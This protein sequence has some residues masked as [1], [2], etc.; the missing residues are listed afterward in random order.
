MILERIY[1]PG[2]AQVG[3]LIGVERAGVAAIIDPRRD[4]GEY[5]ALA[6]AAG[7]RITHAFETHVHADFVSGSL[8][9]ARATGATIHAGKLGELAFPHVPLNDGDVIEIGTLRV[10][11]MWTPGHTPEHVSYLVEDTATPTR[12]LT[13][14]TGD[15]LFVGEVGRP[16][17]LGHGRTD[18]LLDALYDSIFE[19]L[20]PL[21]DDIIVYPGHGAGSACGRTI[22]DADSTTMGQE[23]R[24]N[25][26]FRPR[27]RAA[28]R[29]AIM[30]G[31]PPAPTYYPIL[32]QVNKEG[33]APLEDLPGGE[34]LMVEELERSMAAGALVI[35]ALSPEAFG[36]AHIPGSIFV[37]LGANFPAWMGWLAPYDRDIILVLEHDTAYEAARTDLRRIGLDRV[38]GYLQSGIAAW[39]AS[40]RE[41]TSLPQISVHELR[42]RIE[43]DGLQVLDV[44]SPAEWEEGHIAGAQHRFAAAIAQGN[45]EIPDIE[46]LS[47][48]CGSGYRSSVAASLLQADGRAGVLN[49]IGGMEAW[50]A[51]GFSV[52]ADDS[53]SSSRSESG[54]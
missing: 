40:G 5:I 41:I 11:T 14:F 35:D 46:P 43:R 29:E 25:Y 53:S 38:A 50:K 22:G 24:F 6:E 3:Y 13:L 45:R 52:T 23:K 17:L 1:T 54:R 48:I 36:G 2:L 15:M 18:E 4:V 34:P 19:R 7:V 9:L 42:Q 31:M 27:D 44:R 26:A 47:L 39:E 51:A 16:D 33:A 21:D 20:M 28:F 12:P 8:E 49:V 32:K 30:A 10:R 37:G